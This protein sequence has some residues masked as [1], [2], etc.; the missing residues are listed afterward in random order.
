[1]RRTGAYGQ[2]VLERRRELGLSQA[3]LADRAGVG[4]SHLSLIENGKVELPEPDLRERIAK[5]L[6][7]TD[8]EVM[9]QA[10]MGKPIA[11]VREVAPLAEVV[12]EP[13]VGPR[14][15]LAELLP[16]LDE[17][18]A[19]HLAVHVEFVLGLR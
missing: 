17:R 2:V 5:A 1:M 18:Q 4:R 8:A 10:G 16:L 19:V 11:Q 3:T 12:G 6:G 15:R 9:R 13:P 14:E 7:S